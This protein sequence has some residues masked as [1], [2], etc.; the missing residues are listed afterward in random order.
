[1]RFIAIIIALA[2]IVAVVKR[3]WRSPRPPAA[4]TK[5]FGR[6]VKCAHCGIYIP[7]QEAVHRGEDYYCSRDHL[8][9]H[10]PAH[11]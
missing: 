11:S 5:E 2:I 4:R 3:L 1:M 8:D 6:M 10:D 9:A 7:E